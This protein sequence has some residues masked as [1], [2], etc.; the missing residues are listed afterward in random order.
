M[1]NRKKTERTLKYLSLAI[2]LVFALSL[3]GWPAAAQDE[4]ENSTP[5]IFITSLDFN[6]VDSSGIEGTIKIENLTNS[7]AGDMV[8]VTE[9][10]AGEEYQ[11]WGL[12]S[13]IVTAPLELYPNESKT[14]NFTHPLSPNISDNT[15]HMLVK[16]L[17]RTG[18]V[19]G[20]HMEEI[21]RIEGTN[22]WLSSRVND[23]KIIKDGQEGYALGGQNY[24]PGESPEGYILLTNSTSQA[25]KAYPKITVYARDYHFR[26]Q[27]VDMVSGTAE[28]FQPGETKKVNVSLP[29]QNEPESYLAAV[30]MVDEEDNPVSGVHE[31]RY[32]VE[33]ASAK[34][35]NMEVSVEESDSAVRT[36][37]EVIGP[38]DGTELEDSIVEI[39][40]YN[41]KSGE[42]LK[43]D[44][45]TVKLDSEGTVVTIDTTFGEEIQDL[46]IEAAIKYKDEILDSSELI[47]KGTSLISTPTVVPADVSGTTYEYAVGKL[48]DLG[49]VNGYEDGTFR[50]ERDIT[51]AEFSK[52][53]CLLL[54]KGPEIEESKG[55]TGFDDVKD[56]HWASGYINVAA[57]NQLIKGYPDG[58]FKP[59]NNV[60]YAEAVTILVRALGYT[61]EVEGEGTWPQNYLDKAE[62]IG[63]TMEITFENPSAKASRG[64]VAKLTW[65]TFTRRSE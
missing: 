1:K 37:V 42:L 26:A 21:G 39:K 61:E 53:V 31:F 25:I 62:E 6:K 34:I 52:I 12:V 20:I 56:S 41:N 63:I 36:H 17:T 15:Y 45:Q 19:A 60:T 50:P 58:T 22:Y 64:D 7:F 14:I 59:T 3:A 32:V 33:G 4:E 48:I 57:E 16:I 47:V 30:V 49:I 35:L 55:S 51:R 40:V 65:N 54:D 18:L 44:S 46:R 28:E 10:Y 38:A 2:V 27:P 24:T 5:A 8:Y 11:D 29:G 13:K 9:V 43:E 23:V